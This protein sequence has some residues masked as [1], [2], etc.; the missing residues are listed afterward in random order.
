MNQI[1]KTENVRVLSNSLISELEKKKS[2]YFRAKSVPPTN[3]VSFDG[4]NVCTIIIN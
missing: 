3:R 1:T 2:R 4:P